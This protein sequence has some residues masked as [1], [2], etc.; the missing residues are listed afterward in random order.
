VVPAGD[1]VLVRR[2]G[3]L[4][5]AIIRQLKRAG[6]A[7]AGADRLKLGDHIAV[8]DLVAAARAA[9]LP[10]DDLTLATVLKS[11]W[12][13]STTTTSCASARRGDAVSFVAALHQA[14]EAGDER[15]GLAPQATSTDGASARTHGPFG[16][17]ATWRAARR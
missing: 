16:F 12:S 3:A 9:L 1:I 6:V 10:D 5:E 2:R 13:G 15:A 4:F 7:V 17:Y 14:A 11:P 8:M